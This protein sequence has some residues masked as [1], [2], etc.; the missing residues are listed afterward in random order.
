M[1]RQEEFR[2]RLFSLLCEYNVTMSIV[3]ETVGHSSRVDG[4]NFFAY[5]QYDDNGNVSVD[6]I[7]L[8]VG[9]YED[10]R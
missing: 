5:Q 1:S 6:S 8:T 7:D 2:Q 9:C 10:G 4:I 3:E